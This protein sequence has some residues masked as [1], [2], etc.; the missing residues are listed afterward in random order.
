MSDFYLPNDANEM[1]MADGLVSNGSRGASAG[2][3]ESIPPPYMPD[4]EANRNGAGSSRTNLGRYG[5]D[6]EFPGLR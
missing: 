3:D 1:D 5:K 4:L 6:Q 2:E